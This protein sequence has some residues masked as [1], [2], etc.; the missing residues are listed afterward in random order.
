MI[1]VKDSCGSSGGI[2]SMFS[3]PLVHDAV[4]FIL[5]EKCLIL[6]KL[7][8]YPSSLINIITDIC[9]SEKLR[10]YQVKPNVGVVL[11]YLVLFLCPR[12]TSSNICSLYCHLK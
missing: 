11:K 9:L 3:F 10:H 12:R 8:K 7:S 6:Q 1:T 5:H 2:L 4:Y